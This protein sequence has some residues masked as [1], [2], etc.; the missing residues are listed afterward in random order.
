MSRFF[1]PNT[2]DP[3]VGKII[4]NIL[5]GAGG[6]ETTDE[7]AG[8][9]NII[10]YDTTEFVDDVYDFMKKYQ[11]HTTEF[12][13]F[14]M[15]AD[16]VHYLPTEDESNAL[17]YS[18]MKRTHASHEQ[19]A[20]PHSGRMNYK[21][22]LRDILEDKENPGYG[23]L[24]YEAQFDNTIQF[25]SWSKNYRDANRFAVKFE[26]LMDTY[27]YIFKQKGLLNFRY[28]ARDDDLYRE[29]SNY[30]LYGCPLRYFIRTNAIKLVHEKLLEE[31]AIELTTSI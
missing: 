1:Q 18:I 25:T 27:Q 30:S 7:S 21:W 28:I 19:G 23:V 24:V 9:D 31:I 29:K 20:H 6:I 17:R 14:S 12:K 2:T 4:V 5:Q 22:I 15:T 3:V 26:G 8:W 10:S 13:D 16:F 11:E